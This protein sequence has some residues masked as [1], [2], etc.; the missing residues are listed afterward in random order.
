M[1][2]AAVLLGRRHRETP[3][4]VQLR[5]IRALVLRDMRSRFGRGP[6]SYAVT[7]SLPLVHLISLMLIP[8]VVDRISPLGTDYALF[9]ATGVLP[10][11]LCLYP[12]RLMMLS[13]VDS[14]PLLSFPIIK[15]LDVIFARA[16]LEA[17]IAFTVM[18]FFIIFLNA[19][20]VEVWPRNVAAATGAIFSTLYL[21][22]SLGFVSTIIFK[23]TRAW[24][25]V[26]IAILILMYLTS[27]AF[28]PIWTLPAEYREVLWYNP[29]LHCVEWLRVAYYEGYA[30]VMLNREYLI[31][32]ATGLFASGMLFERLIRGR[33]LMS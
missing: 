30:S 32:Y 17:V 15:P 33:L 11:I 3:L 14:A 29:L 28:F 19:I 23:I 22:L 27:G 12:S 18:F 7:I 21:G 31:G 4:R 9:A 6:A 24:M 2:L 5:V 8:L 26:Y 20:D 10:Y 16:F 25:F 1:T 13:L